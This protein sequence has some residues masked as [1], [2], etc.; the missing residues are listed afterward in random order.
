MGDS[1]KNGTFLLFFKIKKMLRGIK[2]RHIFFVA[3]IQLF[4]TRRIIFYIFNVLLHYQITNL[5]HIL[6]FAEKKK[7]ICLSV[8]YIL[9]ICR[10]ASCGQMI[11]ESDRQNHI[12]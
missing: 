1:D 9:G 11:I 7:S 6:H 5:N 12:K 2:I 4:L 10:A 3:E 8:I